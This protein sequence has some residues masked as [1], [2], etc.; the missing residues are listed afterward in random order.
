MDALMRKVEASYLKESL[1]DNVEVGDVIEVSLRVKEAGKERLQ[2]FEGIVI[3]LKGTGLT[4]SMLVRKQSFGIGV[5]KTIPFH[6][7]V[8]KEY[9]IKKKSKVRRAKL[10]YMRSRVGKR[11]TRLAERK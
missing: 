3:A 5:E 1:G 2:K 9:V 4:R 11:A 6:S 10:Y 7:P 8:L